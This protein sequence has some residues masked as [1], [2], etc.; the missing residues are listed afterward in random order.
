MKVRT[1]AA[2]MVLAAV[3]AFAQ[4]T[5]FPQQSPAG[6]SQAYKVRVHNDKA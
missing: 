1:I 3:P 2:I 6:G 4:V 5:V